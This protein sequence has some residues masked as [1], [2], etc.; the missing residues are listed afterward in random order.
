M[1]ED[2][3]TDLN[4]VKCSVCKRTLKK[5]QSMK[6]I[7]TICEVTKYVCLECYKTSPGWLWPM[8]AHFEPQGE[9]VQK[10]LDE[11]KKKYHL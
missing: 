11:I 1:L 6:M 5:T 10:Y 7:S 8:D 9:I 3:G 2:F 4:W